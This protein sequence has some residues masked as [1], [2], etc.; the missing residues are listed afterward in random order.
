MM[1]YPA[2]CK[3]CTNLEQ[4]PENEYLLSLEQKKNN[5]TNKQI[6]CVLHEFRYLRNKTNFRLVFPTLIIAVKETGDPRE[7]CHQ[8]PVSLTQSFF[9]PAVQI[10]GSWSS[11]PLAL[12]VQTLDSAIQR[13]TQ[14]FPVIRIS[15]MMTNIPWIALSSF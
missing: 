6:N 12:V 14:L 2:S 1:L 11:I 7:N 10:Q 4:R 8:Q 13:I 3:D 9:L 15:W 5:R